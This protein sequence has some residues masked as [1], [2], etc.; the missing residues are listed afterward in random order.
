MNNFYA[1]GDYVVFS[2]DIISSKE[3]TVCNTHS[4]TV[5]FAEKLKKQN[6]NQLKHKNRIYLCCT[7]LDLAVRAPLERH[8]LYTTV[9]GTIHCY[10]ASHSKPNPVFGILESGFGK[11]LSLPPAAF[12]TGSNYLFCHSFI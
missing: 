7:S 1:S 3:K 4:P 10:Q 12:K 8:H 2:V 11:T 6:F 9:Q 5:M